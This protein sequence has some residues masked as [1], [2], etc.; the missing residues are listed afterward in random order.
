MRPCVQNHLQL[1][2][3]F[4]ALCEQSSPQI[5]IIHYSF[6]KECLLCLSMRFIQPD[7]KVKVVVNLDAKANFCTQEEKLNSILKSIAI[8]ALRFHLKAFNAQIIMKKLFNSH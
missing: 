8:R 5:L 3:L 1:G 7:S 2:I 4:V 6:I